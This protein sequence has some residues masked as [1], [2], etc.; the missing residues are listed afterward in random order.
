MFIC[1][2]RS[3]L[4]ACFVGLLSCSCA[5]TVE[6]VVKS[7][8]FTPFVPASTLYAPGTIIKTVKNSPQTYE[9]V[10]NALSS[11]GNIAPDN[12]D[13]YNVNLIE[14][15][16]NRNHISVDAIK[17]IAAKLGFIQIRDVRLRLDN[18]HILDLARNQV[19]EGRNNRSRACQTAIELSAE[20]PM[21]FLTMIGAVIQADVYYEIESSRKFEISAGAKDQ[22]AQVIKGDLEIS[23]ASD[24][25]LVVSGKRLYIGMRSIDS[26]SVAGLKGIDELQALSNKLPVGQFVEMS[27]SDTTTS[28]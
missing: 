24:T 28:N 27:N 19:I 26:S 7:Y 15:L 25:K 20:E 21:T 13:T 5:P 16:K 23:V 9:R 11:V 6:S 18:V 3:A 14:K 4:F 8:G 10:C 1:S 12:S 22:L 17:Q 2:N